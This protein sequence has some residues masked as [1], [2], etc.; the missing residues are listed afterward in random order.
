MKRIEG[1]RIRGV[2]GGQPTWFSRLPWGFLT[3]SGEVL[4]DNE[5]GLEAEKKEKPR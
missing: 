4:P 2:Y 3:L 1:L 5:F